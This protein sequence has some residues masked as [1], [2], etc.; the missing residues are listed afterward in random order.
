MRVRHWVKNFFIFFPVVFSQRLLEPGTFYVGG[1]TFGAFCLCSSGIYLI[2][3]VFDRARDQQ[4]PIKRRRPIASGLIKP[5]QALT[6]AILLLVT[7][8]VTGWAASFSIT[9][10]LLVYV[11]SNLVYSAILRQVPLFDSLWVAVGFLLRVWAG[12]LVIG[13]PPTHWALL[14]TLTLALFL[15]FGKR[16]SEL[17]LLG[18]EAANHRQVLRYYTRE[19]LMIAMGLL[20]TMTVV[21]YSL[22]TISE[23]AIQNFGSDRLFVTVPFVLYGILRYLYLALAEQPIGD[24]TDIVYRDWPLV[25]CVLLWVVSSAFLIY[26]YP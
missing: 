17:R 7:G 15:G 21:F 3:D 5:I 4:H 25:F 18:T 24:P 1:L 13:V 2:N 10:V 19:F 22:F 20:G 12:G 8:G 11:A 16:F 6:L 23:Y 14:T 26:F 9:I